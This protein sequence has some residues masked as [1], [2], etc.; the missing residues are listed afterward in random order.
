MFVQFDTTV[1]HFCA[2]RDVHRRKRWQ[3]TQQHPTPKPPTHSHTISVQSAHALSKPKNSHPRRFVW[4]FPLDLR[5]AN[6]MLFGYISRRACGGRKDA[7]AVRC[8]ADVWSLGVCGLLVVQ[9]CGT[10]TCHTCARGGG[11]ARRTCRHTNKHTQNGGVFFSTSLVSG[12]SLA[13]VGQSHTLP[14]T[15]RPGQI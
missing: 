12:S 15:P 6:L 10:A 4:H 11:D 2:N 8:V 13:G 7:G 5:W 9:W 1:A 3:L 14:P